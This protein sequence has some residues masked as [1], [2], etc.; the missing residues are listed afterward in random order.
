[1]REEAVAAN[2]VLGWLPNPS[3]TPFTFWYLV[4]LLST[5]LVQRVV[6][7]HVSDRLLAL[8]STDAHNLWHHPVAAL[9][10]SA[11]WID[12][13]SWTGYVL[14]FALAVAPLE[15]RIGAGWTF[16]IFASGHVLAT[17]ATEL[18]VMWAIDTGRLPPA[19]AHWL[20]IG[21]SY[22]FFATAGAMAAILT[23]RLRGWAVLTADALIVV[24]YLTDQPGSPLSVVTL[25]GHLIALHIGL[26]GWRAWLRRRGLAGTVRFAW[27]ARRRGA[28]QVRPAV[29]LAG[30]APR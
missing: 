25:A 26:L 13:S 24:I 14:I 15:R 30:S 10:S 3:V 20:D 8:S 17:L 11:L 28:D 2:R 1:M 12:G 4:V 18:P 6:D 7:T 5:T 9:V 19:D 22:G 21:V 29:V 23:P 16:A 27:P